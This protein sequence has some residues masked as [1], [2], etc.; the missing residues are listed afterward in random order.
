MK[1]MNIVHLDKSCFIHC[2][3]HL[4][5]GALQQLKLLQALGMIHRPQ[6]QSSYK[7]IKEQCL[8]LC[9][10]LNF[11]LRKL[12]I[13]SSKF[14]CWYSMHALT[15]GCSALCLSLFG[16][17]EGINFAIWSLP[18]LKLLNGYS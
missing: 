5:L 18:Q 7:K 14:I 10:V 3:C 12:P 17:H 4:E 2:L 1:D 6:I 9:I 15:A 11:G 16:C 13:P 8:M